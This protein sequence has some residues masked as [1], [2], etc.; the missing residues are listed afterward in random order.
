MEMRPLTPPEEKARECLH[1]GE[2]CDT[3]FCSKGCEIAESQ[4]M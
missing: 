2:P 1:C 3:A 4:G